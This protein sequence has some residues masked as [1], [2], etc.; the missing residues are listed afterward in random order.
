MDWCPVTPAMG[1]RGPSGHLISLLDG[2]EEAVKIAMRAGGRAR[3]TNRARGNRL[4]FAFR[5]GRGVACAGSYVSSY[6]DTEILASR[7]F[8]S[9]RTFRL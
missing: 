9:R 5:T 1:K 3:P 8:L 4:L 7:L 6:A 2:P